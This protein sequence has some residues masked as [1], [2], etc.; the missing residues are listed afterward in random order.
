M[1]LRAM[2]VPL[3][4]ATMRVW[5]PGRR[6]GPRP[7]GAARECRWSGS[8]RIPRFRRWQLASRRGWPIQ[9]KKL[10][11]RSHDVYIFFTMKLI[12]V[13]FLNMRYWFWKLRTI[14]LFL[15]FSVWLPRNYPLILKIHTETVLKIPSA[16]TGQFSPTLTAPPEKNRH[17]RLSESFFL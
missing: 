13:C 12:S 9:S 11:G 8:G 3:V 16:V 1:L 5:F 10:I 15:Y 4:C 2:M 7:R 17:K 6:G 14:L